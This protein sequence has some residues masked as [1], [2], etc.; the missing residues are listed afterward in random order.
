MDI[1]ISILLGVV[2]GITEF[3]PVS[4]LGHSIVLEAFLG[5][6]RTIVL[7]PEAVQHA[8]HA[9]ALFIQLGA[10]L[11]V[12]VYYFKDLV[13]LGARLPSDPKARRLTG[14][15]ILAFLPIA[16]LGFLF[17]KTIKALFFSPWVVAISL[18]VG[19]VIFILVESRKAKPAQVVDLEEI[20]WKKALAVGV[21]Q[22]FALIPGVSRSGATIIGGLLVGLERKVVANFSFLLFIPTLGA[23]AGY[24]LF[25]AVKEKN[26]DP[27]LWPYFLLSAGV[28]FLV[29]LVVIRWLLKYISTHNFRVFGIYRILASLVIAG[30]LLAGLAR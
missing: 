5:F 1:L 23:A 19:G 27:A 12:I 10:V 15:L 2:L 29:S 30:L 21:A 13:R 7:T 24:E 25:K 14:N 20:S 9:L 6:P 22:I 28:G 26:L 3:L 11:A 17:N 4:S 8:R 16:L 18:F